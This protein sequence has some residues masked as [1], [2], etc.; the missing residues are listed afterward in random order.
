MKNAS[1]LN[2]IFSLCFVLVS[3]PNPS[4]ALIVDKTLQCRLINISHSKRTV[5]LNRGSEDGLQDGDHA[6]FYISNSDEIFARAIVRK[7]SPRRSLWSV[8]RVINPEYLKKDTILQLS[9]TNPIPLSSDL[10]R[11]NY[12]GDQEAKSFSAE[13]IPISNNEDPPKVPD[14]DA[15]GPDNNKRIFPVITDRTNYSSL[16]EFD[17][18][19][20]DQR[21]NWT[22]V[23]EIPEGP[24]KTIFKYQQ[25]FSILDLDLFSEEDKLLDQKK[26][27]EEGL[28]TLDQ[29]NNP[30]PNSKELENR[31]PNFV[32]LK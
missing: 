24:L 14:E 1:A 2:I 6:K 25:D 22:G 20:R 9:I 23:D 28:F 18:F 15:A 7:V 27:K 19:E 5:L 21:L 32:D 16:N 8:Y 11:E 26:Y 4:Q 3:Y 17:H 31:Y 30:S 29:E 12:L 13:A 10:S